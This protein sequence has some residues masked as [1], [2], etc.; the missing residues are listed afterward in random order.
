MLFSP[1]FPEDNDPAGL[2]IHVPFCKV[3]CSYC[4]F[5][6]GIH[7]ARLETLYLRSV[8]KEIELR[9]KGS[10][11]EGSAL[12]CDTIY[13]GGGTPS[14][15]SPD[16]IRDLIKACRRWFDVPDHPEITLEM[17]PGTIDLTSLAT[18]RSAG[19]NR[20]SL[21][22]QSLLDSELSSM[23]RSHDSSQA[24]SALNDLRLTGFGNISVD[25]IAGFP[26]QTLDSLRRSLQLIL[27]LRP[28]HSS[29]YLLEV[30]NGTRLARLIESKQIPPPDE[31]LVA[32]MYEEICAAAIDAGYEHYEI[33]N[34][35]LPGYASR[36]NLKYWTDKLYLGFGPGA[37]GMTG[38]QRYAN[39]EDFDLYELA[40][41]GGYPPVRTLDEMSPE[42][43]FKDA[44]IMGLRLTKGIDLDF[45]SSR[46]RVD[47]RAFVVDSVG[48]LVPAGLL[49]L[50]D[51]NVRLTEKGRILS[52][53]V[54]SRWV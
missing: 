38:R 46:Y 15:L 41:N 43:R 45:M 29:V 2:Y 5:V 27:D 42:I 37:H 51:N 48:D 30:K 31:D 11:R 21:G 54:F 3:R 23:G 20:A 25:L 44:M 6:S 10:A 1:I 35:A 52:N 4:G 24:L 12:A 50:V 49:D 14:L 33:S 40:I 26:G 19:V 8:S 32:D 22:I 28:E 16:H 17:N 36:H 7:D 47:A 39:E 13:F 9:G 34:F 53:I 18:F